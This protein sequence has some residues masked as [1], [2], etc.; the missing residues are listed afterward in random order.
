ME[1]N[2]TAK[3]KCN[4][5]TTLPEYSRNAK[6]WYVHAICANRTDEIFTAMTSLELALAL[7]PGLEEIARLDSDMMDV[8]ELIRPTE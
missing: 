2:Q 4:E 8:I 5:M 6:F 1:R 3:Q 7:D